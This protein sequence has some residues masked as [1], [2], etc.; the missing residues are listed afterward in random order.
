MTTLT[1][2]TEHARDRYTG[3]DARYIETTYTL[4]TDDENVWR[5]LTITTHYNSDR[6]YYYGTVTRNLTRREVHDYGTFLSSSHGL[7]EK[8]P[9]PPTVLERNVARYSAKRLDELHAQWLASNQTDHYGIARLIEWAED[10][11]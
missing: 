5:E 2:H 11:K 1:P 7:F 3:K 9:V 8:S 4:P 6:H 10:A